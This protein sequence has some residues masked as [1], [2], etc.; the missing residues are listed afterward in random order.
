MVAAAVAERRARG[1]TTLLVTHRLAW[2]AAADDVVVL[3][4]RGG[5]ERGSH[6]DLLEKSGRYRRMWEAQGPLGPAVAA[7]M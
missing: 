5:A 4:E 2:A 6:A 7:S 1:R 3:D